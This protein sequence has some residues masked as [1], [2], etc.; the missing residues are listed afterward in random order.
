MARPIADERNLTLSVSAG[1]GSSINVLGDFSSLRRL[2]WIMLD[3]ALK[4][5][6]APGTVDVKISVASEQATL[7]VSDSGIG[8]SETDLP[9]IFD[10]FYR[11][12][13]SRSQ[14]EGSGLG[15]A[16][17]RWIAEMHHVELSVAS[18]EHKGT[19]F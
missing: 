13:P 2:V 1:S 12:D 9:H 8:I 5:T 14:V 18:T 10:R 4:Y 6:P 3:N 15:L 7:Q 11:T 17:A 16:I 19:T